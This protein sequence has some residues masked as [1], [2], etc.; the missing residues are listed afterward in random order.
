MRPLAQELIDDILDH[1]AHM[2]LNTMGMG[3]FWPSPCSKSLRKIGAL[4]LVCKAWWPR[5]R[6][7]LFSHLILRPETVESFF[8]LVDTSASPILTYVEALDLRFDR[9]PRFMDQA[10]ILRFSKSYKLSQMWIRIPEF[11]PDDSDGELCGAL[12]SHASLFGATVAS[13]SSLYLQFKKI[14]FTSAIQVVTSFPGLETLELSGEAMEAAVL[15]TPPPL[16]VCIHTLKFGVQRGGDSFFTYLLSLPNPPAPETVELDIGHADASGGIVGYL[17]SYG[18]EIRHLVLN[19]ARQRSPAALVALACAQNLQTL[20]IMGAATPIVDYISAVSSEQLIQ[21]RIYQT[22]AVW[23]TDDVESNP[24]SEVDVILAEPQFRKLSF[25]QAYA[26]HFIF[27]G[28]P[29]SSRDF[30]LDFTGDPGV[31]SAMP[32]ANGRGILARPA[33]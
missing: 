2:L 11:G 18:R 7:H 3:E 19:G 23:E 12:Q 25:F 27:S 29:P 17:R 31:R 16:S 24:W 1:T 28:D 26:T 21:L 10:Q 14:R 33:F 22:I 20:Y 6:F 15:T 30:H 8:V 9:S 5:S 13:I 4:G 32:L